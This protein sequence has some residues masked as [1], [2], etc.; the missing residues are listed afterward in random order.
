MGLLDGVK[1]LGD[2]NQMRKTAQQIQSQLAAERVE[3]VKQ[4]SKG[5]LKIVLT[6]DQ[7]VLEV[8]LDG[9]R[10]YE[11]EAALGEALYKSQMVAASK[12]Q[13]LSGGMGGLM[14]GGGQ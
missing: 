12:L 2:L 9:V 5:T 3:V 1:Q 8:S 6:G 10:D 4:T 14:G 7:K 11:L 13:Q